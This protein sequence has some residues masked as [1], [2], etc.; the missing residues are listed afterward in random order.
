MASVKRMR[1]EPTEK[2]QEIDDYEFRATLGEGAF[3]KVKL[4][5]HRPSKDLFAI[6]VGFCAA[7]RRWGAL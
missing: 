6:K 7:Q 5:L 3:G 2:I 1:Q 4:A